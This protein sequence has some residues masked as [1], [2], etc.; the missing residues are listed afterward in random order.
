MQGMAAETDIAGWCAGIVGLLVKIG[1]SPPGS[2][3]RRENV[4]PSFIFTLA[5]HE[6]ATRLKLLEPRTAARADWPSQ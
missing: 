2:S 5:P 4:P 6:G 3:A 1:T